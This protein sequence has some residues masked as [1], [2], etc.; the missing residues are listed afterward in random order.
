MR[1]Q[2]NH[3][4]TYHDY[5]SS[6]DE[7]RWEIIDGQAYDM[8]PAP[9]TAHQRIVLNL[10]R[11]LAEPAAARGC[12]VFVAPTDVVLDER[13]VVQP[14]LL[15]VCD[16]AKV[17]EQAVHG[18]PDVVAEVVSPSTELKDRRDK[19]ALYERFG[20]REYLL[21]HAAGEYLER[22]C[23]QEGHYGLPELFNWDEPVELRVLDG[24]RLDL[25]Q[26]FGKH[27]DA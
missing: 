27:E 14:D 7:E 5:L 6:P 15:V 25:R 3:A 26:V 22:Y 10:A 4:Y 13:N 19:K 21:V 24:V 1:V 18:A 12:E 20:V 11:L 9:S 2:P 17:T 23:L 16:P 8:S